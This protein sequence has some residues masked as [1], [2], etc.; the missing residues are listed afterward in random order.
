LSA[1]FAGVEE[2]GQIVAE[3]ESYQFLFLDFRVPL[4]IKRAQE[5]LALNQILCFTPKTFTEQFN[6][7]VRKIFRILTVSGFFNIAILVE[8]RYILLSCRFPIPNS[9]KPRILYLIL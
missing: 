6:K 7:S 8:V 4:L 9:R 3:G 5:E 2:V 1:K